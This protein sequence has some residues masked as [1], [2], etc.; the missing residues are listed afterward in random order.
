MDDTTA[1]TADATTNDYTE[2]VIKHN[3]IMTS[4]ATAAAAVLKPDDH[5]RRRPPHG[6]GTMAAGKDLTDKMFRGT[7]YFSFGGS[8]VLA[9]SGDHKH[10]KFIAFVRKT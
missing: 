1:T 2:T 4:S 6:S 7:E 8:N 10:Q 3:K 9:T 5:T